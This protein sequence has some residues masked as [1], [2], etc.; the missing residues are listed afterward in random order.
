M[1]NACRKLTH[2]ADHFQGFF[3]IVILTRA[4]VRC[5]ADMKGW[6]FLKSS[7]GDQ[8]IIPIKLS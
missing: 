2:C 3:I 7:S 8:T 1:V 6:I 5:Q 4:A